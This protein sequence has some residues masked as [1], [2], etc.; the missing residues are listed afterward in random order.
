[1][2]LHP[3]IVP[4]PDDAA[5]YNQDRPDRNAP[6]SQTYFRFFDRHL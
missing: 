2:L 3:L 6:I 1:M 5:I 4:P